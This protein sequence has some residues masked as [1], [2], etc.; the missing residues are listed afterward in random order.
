M[1]RPRKEINWA[2]FDGL[3]DLQ[4]TAEEIAHWFECSV[5]TIERA[6]KREK[7]MGF[8]EYYERKK[9]RG[10]IALRRQMMQMALRGDRN[11]VP[12]LIY[13]DKKYLG[14]LPS[15]DPDAP[16]FTVNYQQNNLQVVNSGELR[17]VPTVELIKTLINRGECHALQVQ[18][19]AGIPVREQTQSGEAVRDGDATNESFAGKQQP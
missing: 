6:V 11:S 14:G 16:G 17:D 15:P 4:C 1:A 7:K 3:C 9:G 12:I 19:P 18:S 13:L 10:K 5:D 2:D 8:A